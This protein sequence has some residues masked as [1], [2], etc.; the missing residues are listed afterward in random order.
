MAPPEPQ[1]EIAASLPKP[2]L[3]LLQ[4]LF[5]SMARTS[6][7]DPRRGEYVVM[8]GVGAARALRES[9]A[10]EPA[11]PSDQPIQQGAFAEVFGVPVYETRWLPIFQVRVLP[12][13]RVQPRFELDWE[14]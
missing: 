10:K 11:R 13:P 7:R 2:P 1:R 8:A 14:G 3:E 9:L 4:E 6:G 12:W 5:D